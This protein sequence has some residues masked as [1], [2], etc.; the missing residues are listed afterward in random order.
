MI[1]GASRKEKRI[2]ILWHTAVRQIIGR[3]C[4]RCYGVGELLALESKGHAFGGDFE[5]GGTAL[6][7][8]VV[9]LFVVAGG[10]LHDLIFICNF[11]HMKHLLVV[12]LVLMVGLVTVVTGCRDTRVPDD[13]RLVTADSLL[14]SAP[15]ALSPSSRR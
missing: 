12:I 7:H 15:T 13:A 14:A 8:R 6:N 9:P 3:R 5:R 4:C 1:A 11:A 2:F 10:H